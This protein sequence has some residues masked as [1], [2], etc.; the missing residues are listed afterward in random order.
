MVSDLTA[1]SE[2]P[3]ILVV[4]KRGEGVVV[5][6]AMIRIKRFLFGAFDRRS[7]L[8]VVIVFGA[9]GIIFLTFTHAATPSSSFE[10]EAGTQTGTTTLSDGSASGGSAIE[11]GAACTALPFNKP[12]AATEQS[13]AKKVFAYYFPPFPLSVD[14][15]NPT[16]DS[17]SHWFESY[18]SQNG[19]YDL[20]DRPLSPA[21]QTASNW[22]EADFEI[23]VRQAEAAG[24][25]GFIWEYHD[26]SDA[27]WNE[28][29]DMLAAAHAVDPGFRI[30]LSPDF[31]TTAGA[32]TDSVYNDVMVVK[33]NAAIYKNSAGDIVLAPF[34]PER[35]PA[36][37]WTDLISRLSSAGVKAT[38]NPIFLSWAQ[39]QYPEWNTSSLTGYSQWGTRT[40]SGIT[41]LTTDTKQAHNLGKLWMQPI[42]FEDTRSYDGRYW[43]ASNSSLLRDSFTSAIQ[44][45]ADSI[46]MITWND[47]TESWMEPSQERGHT[48]LN[49]SAY[50]IDWFKTGT[51]P[52]ITN[53][54]LYWFHR[55]QPTTAP[56]SSQPIGRSGQPVTMNIANGDPAANQVELLAFLKTPGTLVIKQDSNVQTEAAPAG[57]VSFKVPLVAGTTPVFEL[58][59][60]GVTT[61]TKTSDTP[62]RS[63]VAYQDMMYHAGGGTANQCA[64]Q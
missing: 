37:W 31:P 16:S 5:Q 43:E 62:I 32:T 41:G 47:Y 52:A 2:R 21:P 10:V 8:I 40:D 38:L 15:K 19:A 30:M 27:R 39:G 7:P 22:K 6:R 1:H 20:R 57:V 33:N 29:P 11:F 53:D 17:Y 42:A 49:V 56:F 61:L 26:S 4:V 58:Q 34:Y 14:N 46:A 60:G 25:D 12:S 45:G 59:R 51:A 13:Y 63:S 3:I 23:E 24:L 44:N 35:Q 36:T 9:V 50:Y 28:L 55:S 48:I 54:A 18:N 64:Q